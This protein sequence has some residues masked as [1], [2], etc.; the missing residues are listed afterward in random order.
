MVSSY[1]ERLM[2]LIV[3][4]YCSTFEQTQENT[5]KQKKSMSRLWCKIYTISSTSVPEIRKLKR[6]KNCNSDGQS[7]N[8]EVEKHISTGNQET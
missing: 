7:N 8:M 4:L 5:E 1:S 2:F 6:T 3:L